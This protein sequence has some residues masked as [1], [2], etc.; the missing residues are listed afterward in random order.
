VQ[1]HNAYN[2]GSFI[3]ALSEASDDEFQKFM[4][5]HLLTCEDRTAIADGGL[6]L[7]IGVKP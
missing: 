3:E 2:G 5:R 4:V 1:K 6:G 7:W